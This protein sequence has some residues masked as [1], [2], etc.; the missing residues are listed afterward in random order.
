MQSAYLFAQIDDGDDRA[1]ALRAL[2]HGV[3]RNEY[4]GIADRGRRHATNGCLGMTMVMHV[5]IIEHDL[6]APAQGAAPVGLAF[7]EAVD[8]A[9]V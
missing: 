8:D 3:N 5:G 1:A 2:V 9:P 7:H 4:G 6:T